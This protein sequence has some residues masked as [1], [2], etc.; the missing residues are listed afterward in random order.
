[1]QRELIVHGM[2]YVFVKTLQTQHLATVM[3]K[4]TAL[5][6]EKNISLMLISLKLWKMGDANIKMKSFSEIDIPLS[7]CVFVSFLKMQ[8]Y[9]QN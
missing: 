9:C 1:M 4:M 2:E 3:K 5:F 7:I 6:T 8:N